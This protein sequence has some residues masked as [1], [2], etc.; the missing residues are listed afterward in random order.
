MYFSS[1]SRSYSNFTAS[2]TCM[3]ASMAF[4]EAMAG[5]M[6][7]AISLTR[8]GVKYSSFCSGLREFRKL[9]VRRLAAADTKARH[10][11]SSLSKSSSP[12]RALRSRK[13]CAK[14]CTNVSA[15][16]EIV[17]SCSHCNS[18]RPC[19]SVTFS[20]NFVCL[21][22]SSKGSGNRVEELRLLLLPVY[23]YCCCY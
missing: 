21:R 12:T 6:F 3:A 16:S 4:V 15:H 10:R 13:S 2:E 20:G 19:F 7:P 1:A 8:R 11:S 9:N 22:A 18:F 23:C 5:M 14:H 17:C